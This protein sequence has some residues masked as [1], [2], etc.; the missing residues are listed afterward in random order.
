MRSRLKQ[1]GGGLSC[2][3]KG[4]L[5]VALTRP[6]EKA[7]ENETAEQEPTSEFE[8]P[9][10]RRRSVS[11]APDC[12]LQRSPRDQVDRRVLVESPGPI[13]KVLPWQPKGTGGRGLS[14][15]AAKAN[16]NPG[17]GKT[18][19]QKDAQATSLRFDVPIWIDQVVR[20]R[21]NTA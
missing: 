1:T 8:K 18:S 20:K 17:R 14:K 4:W 9:D 16:H 19:A 10:S 5:P 6:R 13:P 3:V 7:S 15:V 11:A 2:I 12:S 21:T